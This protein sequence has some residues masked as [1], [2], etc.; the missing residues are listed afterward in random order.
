MNNK[1]LLF[2]SALII[3]T[4]CSTVYKSIQTTDDVYYSPA[5]T[6]EETKKDNTRNNTRDNTRDNMRDN[7]RDNLNDRR[8]D[9]YAYEAEMRQIRMG[10]NDR[11]WRNFDNDIFYNPYMYGFNYGYYYNPFYYS[12]PVYNSFPGIINNPKNNTPRITNLNAYGTGYTNNNSTYNPKTGTRVITPVR[13]YNNNG[14]KLGNVLRNIITPAAPVYNNNNN[15]NSRSENNNGS[16]PSRNYTPSSGSSG[17]SSSGGTISR[18]PR[19]GN[20][21]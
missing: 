9:D 10:F 21:N 2:A 11:R 5:R 19:N 8:Y 6:Y 15:N 3:F 1:L 13:G 4:S 18:P 20:N 17:S 16:Q 14:S 7:N 12:L